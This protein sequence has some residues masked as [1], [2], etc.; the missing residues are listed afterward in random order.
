M[1]AGG[2]GTRLGELA[3]ET[4]K[5]LVP[6]GGTP[7]ADI[8]LRWLADQGVGHVVYSI[9][10]L[11]D[12]IRAFVGD[13]GRW[14]IR[15]DYVDDGDTLR[16]TGGGLR[17]A[18][19]A[20][21]LAERSFVLYGDSYLTV[22][23]AEM[24]RSHLAGGRPATMA[25]FRNDG[26]YDSSNVALEEGRLIRY[27]KSRPPDWAPRMHHIDYGISVFDRDVVVSEI[28]ADAV[29]D[30]ADLQHRLSLDDR[31]GAYEVHERFYE[32]GTPE[33]LAELEEHL[34]QTDDDPTPLPHR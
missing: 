23:L 12:Q 15:V 9:G 10:H 17:L 21:V 27:D 22:D 6:V 26:R 14:G 8:Q 31:L 4:P 33:G 19:D 25:V 3:R 11:G 2:R 30:L 7:F 18:A 29:S 13:G 16:G 1:L 28:P 24:W 5:T 20:G 32:I 34:A